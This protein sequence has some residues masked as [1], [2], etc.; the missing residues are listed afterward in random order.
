MRGTARFHTDEA[1]WHLSKKPQHL[2]AAQPLA[3]S[4]LPAAPTP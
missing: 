1:Q 3:Y 2:S 4:T